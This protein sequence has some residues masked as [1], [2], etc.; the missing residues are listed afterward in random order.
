MRRRR[1]SFEETRSVSQWRLSKTIPWAPADKKAAAASGVAMP[2][3][4]TRSGFSLLSRIMVRTAPYRVSVVSGTCESGSLVPFECDVFDA[5]VLVENAGCEI[6]R[7]HDREDVKITGQLADP[8]EVMVGVL[9]QEHRMEF[10]PESSDACLFE[11]L[12]QSGVH[13]GG[14]RDLE[15]NRIACGIGLQKRHAGRFRLDCRKVEYRLG[16][17]TAGR[18]HNGGRDF[19][20]TP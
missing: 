17:C 20:L 10:D 19:F 1:S 8:L 6:Y 2:P 14:R 5:G 12:L 15:I 13:Q 7:S 4:M 16:S 3:Q 11:K 18:L 9:L